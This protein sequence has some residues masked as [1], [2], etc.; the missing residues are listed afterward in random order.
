LHEWIYQQSV[1]LRNRFHIQ[2]KYKIEQI[3]SQENLQCIDIWNIMQQEGI[4]VKS[5]FLSISSFVEL[6]KFLEMKNPIGNFIQPKKYGIKKPHPKLIPFLSGLQKFGLTNL[7]YEKYML[8]ESIQKDDIAW[9]RWGVRYLDIHDM[10]FWDN[11][12]FQ[13]AIDYQ[14][15]KTIEFI[16]EYDFD[17]FEEF[18]LE[19]YKIEIHE[20]MKPEEIFEILL[21][22]ELQ[23]L[24][25]HS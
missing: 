25:L 24:Q 4:H 19:K 12:C 16:M 15:S 11:E 1:Y 14:S 21:Q 13:I 20:E 2:K 22:K 23:S 9:I 3:V 5:L 17:V 6:W 18:L 8:I 10:D 7:S